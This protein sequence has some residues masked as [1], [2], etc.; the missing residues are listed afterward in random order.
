MLI[1][2]RIMEP[3]DHQPQRVKPTNSPT[4][5]LQKK[6]GLPQGTRP[7]KIQTKKAAVAVIFFFNKKA[8]GCSVF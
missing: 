5:M 3:K 8:E 7:V 1:P 6:V 4:Q 2:R